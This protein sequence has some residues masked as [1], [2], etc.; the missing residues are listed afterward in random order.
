MATGA[1][2]VSELGSLPL[3]P[4]P[5]A[6]RS[7]WPTEMTSTHEPMN[8]A[9]ERLHG[10][11]RDKIV[12][13]LEP[14][15]NAHGVDAVE[16]VWRTDRGEPVLELTIERP[17]T[18][19]PG[20]GVTVEL[21]SEISRDV[22]AAL[23]VADVIAGHYRLEVGSPG[24]DRA[25]YGAHDYERFAGQL[26]KL[27][28]REPLPDGQ[29]VVRGTLQGIERTPDGAA[30]VV[31]STERGEL[32]IGLVE[33]ESARLVFDWNSAARSRPTKGGAKPRRGTM[34]RG[35]KA[36]GRSGDSR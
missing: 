9:H 26:A 18:R 10:L 36:R 34:G 21:C 29:R 1:S 25:L 31:F 27:K 6:A 19:V 4:G 5:P 24:L 3:A 20:E 17:E 7:G 15:L 30:R 32:E 16:L 33:I 11:D 14:I 28:L 2:Q 22:S 23:D 12:A 8:V 35:P 13:A